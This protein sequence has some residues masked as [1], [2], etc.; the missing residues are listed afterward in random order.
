MANIDIVREHE[1]G[2]AEAKERAEPLLAELGSSFGV[3]GNWEG[4]RFLI[5]SPA[6]GT[7]DVSDTSVRVQVDLPMFLTPMKGMI[8]SKIEESLDDS[9]GPQTQTG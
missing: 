8:E 4:D 5:T 7:L 2:T 6:K 1:L 9:L 3:R